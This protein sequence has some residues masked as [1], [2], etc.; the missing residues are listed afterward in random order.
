MPPVYQTTSLRR[1]AARAAHRSL[2]AL[3]AP[4]DEIAR[5]SSNLIVCQPGR[6]ELAG[7]GYE[8]PRY[9]FL[10]PAGGGIP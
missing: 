3:T 4:L 5:D 2:E 10:G 6:F 9:L 7:Q 1:P 8:L